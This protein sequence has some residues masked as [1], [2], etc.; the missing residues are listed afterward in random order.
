MV[1]IPEALVLNTSNND[2]NYYEIPRVSIL[3][4]K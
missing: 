1:V 4:S 3:G 2:N